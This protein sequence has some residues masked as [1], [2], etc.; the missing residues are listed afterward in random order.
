MV[1]E[2]KDVL[3]LRAAPAVDALVVIAHDAD[4][5]RLSREKLDQLELQ[6]VG[7]LIFVDKKMGVYFI[8]LREYSG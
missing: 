3:H 2:V 5:P 4:V 7:V 8:V 1:R 6:V